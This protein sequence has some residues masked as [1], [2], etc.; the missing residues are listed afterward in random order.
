MPALGPIETQFDDAIV[1]GPVRRL[2]ALLDYGAPP[3]PDGRLPPLG[4]WLFFLPETRQ[5]SIGRDGHPERGDD[6]PP[7][8]APR[9]MWAGG[10]IDF[11]AD[12]PIGGIATRRSKVVNV[13]EKRGRSGVLTFV[14]VRHEILCGGVPAIV[15]LQDLVYR[16]DDRRGTPATPAVSVRSAIREAEATRTVRVDPAILFRFSALT[17]NAHRI[18]YDLPYATDVER[19]SGLV[20]QGPLQAVLLVDHLLRTMP[21]VRLAGFSFRGARPLIAG[22]AFTV[23][24]VSVD[25]GVALWTSD[26]EGHECMRAMAVLA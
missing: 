22:P 18:H 13:E 2:A 17:F 15:E 7:I 26:D 5:S 24:L 20:V 4:H 11:L 16:Q 1:A 12:V 23:N 6:L 14:T 10:R 25:G 8:E 21:G 3:W 19:Y 9:R